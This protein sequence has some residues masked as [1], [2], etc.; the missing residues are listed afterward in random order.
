[1][2]PLLKEFLATVIRYGLTIVLARLEHAGVLTS[3]QV[4]RMAGP[5]AADILAWLVVLLPLAWGLRAKYVGFLKRLA[6]RALPSHSSQAAI[7]D[8]AKDPDIKAQAFSK[9]P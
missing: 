6:A 3:D 5:F 9:N 4:T 1:M 8:R 7:D 2:S